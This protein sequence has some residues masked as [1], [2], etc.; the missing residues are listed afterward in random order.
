MVPL[1]RVSDS[2]ATTHSLGPNSVSCNS[3]G[4]AGQYPITE[5]PGS[6]PTRPK[7]TKRSFQLKYCNLI[8]LFLSYRANQGCSI[9]RFDN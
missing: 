5:V 7:F 9:K 1:T 2:K 8:F 4:G 6:N 3:V